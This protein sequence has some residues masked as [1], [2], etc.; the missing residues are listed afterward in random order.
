[1]ANMLPGFAAGVAG[2][3]QRM[4]DCSL[5]TLVFASR[6]AYRLIDSS[7][8]LSAASARSENGY[9]FP[10]TEL[11]PFVLKRSENMHIYGRPRLIIIAASGRAEQ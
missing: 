10:G 6:S 4:R 5:D 2:I 9:H 7:V 1:M 3:T 11:A 8:A